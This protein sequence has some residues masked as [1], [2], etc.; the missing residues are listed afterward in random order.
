[1]LDL[2]FKKSLI[3]AER[4]RL[5]SHIYLLLAAADLVDE[6]LF[7]PQKLTEPLFDQLNSG[8][9]AFIYDDVGSEIWRSNSASVLDVELQATETINPGSSVFVDF[10]VKDNAYYLFSFDVAYELEDE[11]VAPYRFFVLHLQQ[12]VKSELSAYRKQLW[13]LLGGLAFLLLLTQAWIMRWGLRPL[14]RVAADL[15]AVEQGRA[16]ILQGRYPEEIQPVTDNL[17]QVLRTERTQRERYK[18][19]L[20][21]L[22]HSL[23][24]PLA[25]MRGAQD[26]T[27]AGKTELLEEQIT[28]MDQIISHQLQRA[29]IGGQVEPGQ[30]VDVLSL[31]TRIKDVLEK[32]YL[33]K[34]VIFHC[35]ANENVYFYGAESDLMEVLGNVMENAFKYCSRQVRVEV[36]GNEREL[37]IAVSDDGVGVPEDSKKQILKRGSRADTVRPGQGIGL[38]VVADIIS[39]Y[40]G[41]LTV[42]KSILGGAEFEITLPR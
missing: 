12:E 36:R 11:S 30:K 32:V 28:R 40:Q 22:A 1:M 20:A 14:K 8:L 42:E 26:Q 7:L 6:E 37:T 29:V 2:A 25:V 27:G 31:V 9:Y 19:T 41:G 23:K 35:A 21:D 5:N 33:D 10:A 38:S 15:E 17:N 13:W 34:N 18:T 16:E 39:S 3:E 4:G 24:T